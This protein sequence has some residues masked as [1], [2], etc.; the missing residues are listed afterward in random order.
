M[1]ADIRIRA[2]GPPQWDLLMG[3][4]ER[5]VPLGA[6]LG[7]PPCAAEVRCEWIGRALGHKV[8]VAAFSPAGNVVG[9]GFLVADKAGSA[10]LAIFV[11]QESRRRGVGT[12]LV[13]AALE[14]EARRVCGVF[15]A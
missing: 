2:V 12:A 13:M 5:F 9:H 8:N 15:G 11:H 10:E 6:A 1:D 3:M 7:L 4:Y 14:W